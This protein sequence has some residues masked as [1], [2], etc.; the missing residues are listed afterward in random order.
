MT[1]NDVLNRARAW[2]I[3]NTVIDMRSYIDSS[4]SSSDAG[5]CH[6]FG[7]LDNDTIIVGS[8]VTGD[9][10]TGAGGI[11]Y[12]GANWDALENNTGPAVTALASVGID[13]GCRGLLEAIGYKP[14]GSGGYDQPGDFGNKLSQ[15]IR[16][17]LDPNAFYGANI[18]DGDPG[19][20]I[21]YAILDYYLKNV[22]GWQY[23]QPYTPND[24]AQTEA[25]RRN[26]E[27]QA[28]GWSGLNNN[29]HY[30]TYTYHDGK[31]GENVYYKN[32]GTTDE[33]YVGSKSGIA[34]ATEDNDTKIDCGDD[35]ADTF[36][37]NLGDHHGYADAYAKLLKPGGDYTPGT[38]E[39]RYGGGTATANACISGFAHKGDAA[40]CAATFSDN[41]AL[42]DA[43]EYGRTK[44][45]GTTG[46][47]T[48]E[49]ADTKDQDKTTCAIPGVG[50]IVCPVVTFLS[51]IT[52]AAYT[53]VGSL[54]EVQPLNVNGASGIFNAWSLMRNFANI[55]FVGAFLVIIFSQVTGA[56]ISNYGIKK[57]LPRLVVAAILVNVSYWICAI[58]VDLSNILGSSVYKLFTNLQNQ[59]GVPFAQSEAFTTGTGWTGLAGGLIAGA[60]AAGVLFYVGLSVLLPL[61]VVVLA[62]I[63]TVFLALI[64]RQALIILLIVVSPLAFVAYLLPNTESLFKKWRSFLQVLLLM[65]PVLGLIFGASAL[66]STI[67]MNSSDQLYIKIAGAAV[68][69]IPLAL[70]PTMIG[71]VNKIAGRFGLPSVGVKLGGLR[72]RAD[73]RRELQEGRRATRS[74]DGERSF[75]FGKYKRTAKREAI[76]AG[77]KAN[78]ARASQAYIAKAMT[79]ANGNPTRLARQISGGDPAAL[80]RALAG[81]QFTLEKAEAEEVQAHHATI[82]KMD[83]VQLNNVLANNN[84]PDTM[85]AAALERLVQIGSMDSIAAAVDQVGA[86]G[87]S[88]VMT[89]SLASAL[90]KDGPGVFKA[91]DIDNIARGQLGQTVTD[92]RGNQVQIASSMQ[93]IA[94]TNVA[95]GVYSPEKLVAASNDELKYVSDLAN[96]MAAAGDGRA[97]GRLYKAAGDAK[98]NPT[99]RGKIKH[100]VDSINNLADHGS[101]D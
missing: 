19:P 51:K 33:V 27:A 52:D 80:Q 76:A 67:I 59:V 44:A 45:T 73:D 42:L 46:I 11:L 72:K 50:W 29:N 84:A 89:K 57:L 13:G 35:T 79:D 56:G 74:L 32:G 60:L 41:K 100:N 15:R 5:S 49:D 34:T 99:L 37:A 85:K 92:V 54:M 16:D 58:A 65:Y 6:I 81:A 38:C 9:N 61:L 14:N 1:A 91:S 3:L 53:I 2:S 90:Q 43:C 95:A 71:A 20:A 17:A 25:G 98:A 69:I 86:S 101:V 68:T 77:V 63:I 48:P 36:G 62:T 28:N 66:A 22:C 8:H 12:A 39:D 70:A 40:F 4:I 82:D 78:Q 75:S 24:Q 31:A 21:T 94:E 10:S 18:G 88:N 93:E 96:D 64:I 83:E 7:N 23:R 30:H 87:E 97:I 47:T 55:A 26:R